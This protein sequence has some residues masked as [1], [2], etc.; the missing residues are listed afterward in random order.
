MITQLKLFVLP[1]VIVLLQHVFLHPLRH[2]MAGVL[3]HDALD[4]VLRE[5]ILFVLVC[6][7]LELQL[8]RSGSF[9]S[10]CYAVFG[11]LEIFDE[12]AIGSRLCHLGAF[13]LYNQY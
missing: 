5:L 2:V 13:H 4:V 12:V 1:F 10:V 9:V 8:A 7:L 11:L 6:G 3:F